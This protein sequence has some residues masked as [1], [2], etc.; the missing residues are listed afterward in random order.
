MV[1]LSGAMGLWLISAGLAVAGDGLFA[2]SNSN[3]SPASLR[4]PGRVIAWIH[5]PDVA[6]AMKQ[7]DGYFRSCTMD[8]PYAPRKS[9]L[10]E[11]LPEMA[12]ELIT[13]AGNT[14][15]DL[16][17]MTDAAPTTG[18][19]EL[20][21]VCLFRLTHPTETL[22]RLMTEG[23]TLHE[24]QPNIY[25]CKLGNG[26][27]LNV[28]VRDGV[29]ALGARLPNAEEALDVV[30]SNKA[31]AWILRT[32]GVGVGRIDMQKA[33]A[34]L[35]TSLDYQ[36]APPPKTLV[37]GLAATPANILI[38]LFAY[39]VIDNS[40]LADIDVVDITINAEDA[41]LG[42][43]SVIRPRD[44]SG[45][46]RSA[47]A[48]A[49]R[50]T[51][52]HR[53][54]SSATAAFDMYLDQDPLALEPFHQ[55][56]NETVHT[57]SGVLDRAASDRLAKA[58]RELLPLEQGGR[59]F[60]IWPESG[61]RE[62]YVVTTV[63]VS[64]GLRYMHAFRDALGEVDRLTGN[65]RLPQDKNQLA[66]EHC[67][68]RYRQRAGVTNGI[69]FDRLDLLLEWPKNQSITPA[70]RSIKDALAAESLTIAMVSNTLVTVRGPQ[71]IEVLSDVAHQ[72]L[73]PRDV[74][75][76]RVIGTSPSIGRMVGQ[77]RLR[78]LDT[79]RIVS[80]R[81]ATLYPDGTAPLASRFLMAMPS[82]RTPIAGCIKA[83]YEDGKAVFILDQE[84]PAT[85]FTE[86][87]A[88]FAALP[89][90]IEWGRQ[91]SEE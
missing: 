1:S 60:A 39:C 68:V 57:I 69:E 26:H 75:P 24:I 46:A 31:G 20:S 55:S 51:S 73:N 56:L 6:F 86:I 23:G 90:E 16:L 50:Q 62:C 79:L 8:T 12:G 29:V 85:V 58:M 63:E 76:T 22:K 25:A 80:W 41:I 3:P 32:E 48:Y 13:A 91:R 9:V 78:V 4:L 77:Y 72:V 71:G 27:L 64:N 53:W 59:R 42:F 45:L 65:I 15:G 43:D 67:S 36:K 38:D 89:F 21:V 2:G 14:P 88:G 33:L 11:R 17:V 70:W 52:V 30:A 54:P 82:S 28:L 61:G 35:K 74:D 37:G 84:I 47:K 10:R 81:W 7:A 34:F 83:R 40:L 66:P 44:A 19:P 5:L 87:L 18:H 49:L